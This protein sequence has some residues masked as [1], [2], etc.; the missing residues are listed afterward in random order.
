METHFYVYKTTNLINGKIYVGQLSRID[1][2]Y[3]GSGTILRSAIEKYGKQNFI[4]ETIEVCRTRDEMN[5][6]E[7]YWIA[8]LQSQNKN[9]GYNIADG[10]EGVGSDCM[11]K[12]WQSEEYREMQRIARLDMDISDEERS[13]R[14]ECFKGVRDDVENERR[15]KESLKQVRSSVEYIENHKK[16][17][18][19]VWVGADD[20]KESYRTMMVD[21]WQCPEYVDRITSIRKSDEYRARLSMTKLKK[22]GGYRP[23]LSKEILKEFICNGRK[24]KDIAVD[25][26]VTT[27]VLHRIIRDRFDGLTFRE[28]KRNMNG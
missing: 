23:D 6:R 4:R 19:D 20:R 17:C 13:R 21:R 8:A 3:R 15:R 26:G 1:E 11:K 22:S 24:M 10:G 9:V 7:R 14:R 18:K 25:V 2:S 28:V 27:K 16:A 12:K 5:E